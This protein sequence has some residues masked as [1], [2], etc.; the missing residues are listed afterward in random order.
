MATAVQ[1]VV[2]QSS[3]EFVEETRF[4]I[5]AARRILY[6][7]GMDSQIGGHVSVRVP[8]ED[9]FWVTPFQYFDETLP[10]HISKVGFDLQIR[11]PGTL[12]PSPGINFHASI[13][14]ARA[15]VNCVIHTHSRN[16]S[17]L[18]T[19][20]RPL[21]MYY[22]YASIFLDDVA[23]FTD[24]GFVTPEKEGPLIVEC[25]GQHRAAFMSHHG[26]VHVGDTLENTTVEALV[27]ELCASY[28][29]Q[30]MAIGG[31]EMRRDVAESYK[32]SYLRYGFRKQ[33][34][35]ANFRRLQRSD[36]DLFAARGR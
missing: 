2:A 1:D 4:K 17:I 20:G 25:L 28:Q 33:M 9:A 24:N 19:T 12:R 11:E 7:E 16:I 14:Q 30:A 35:E 26:A 34:W 13:Y 6:R 5:A 21:G 8:G 29:V 32:A 15:D 27:L 18:S 22:V 3:D 36:P 23:F 31:A 10:E